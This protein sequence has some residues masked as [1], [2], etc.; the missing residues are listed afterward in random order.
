MGRVF[1]ALLAYG[2]IPAVP[3]HAGIPLGPTS[4]DAALP[5]AVDNSKLPAF[6]PMRYMGYLKSCN[7][8]A[9]TYYQLTHEVA[10]A[11]GWTAE[12]TA[13]RAFSPKWTYN[14]ANDGKDQGAPIGDIY[15][16]LLQ[17]GAPSWTAFPY[18]ET[19]TIAANYTDWTTQP[20]IWLDALNYRIEQAGA[21]EYGPASDPT[22]IKGPTSPGLL[23]L[24]RML[25]QGH[26]LLVHTPTGSITTNRV[27]MAAQESYSSHARLLVG[28]DDAKWV[29]L[30]ANGARDP[31]EFGAFK[32]L[33]N[34]PYAQDN[35]YEWLIYDA[36]N[37]V[38]SVANAQAIY[39]AP[40]PEHSGWYGMRLATLNPPDRTFGFNDRRIY[41]VS[42]RPSYTPKLLARVTV[43]TGKRN[44]GLIFGVSTLD[45]TMPQATWK[46][47]LLDADSYGLEFN[48][49]RFAT[50]LLFDLT[51]LASDSWVRDGTAKRWYVQTTTGSSLYTVY[52]FELVDPA[53]NTVLAK[54]T[55]L[56]TSP[57]KSG[58]LTMG[59][60]LSMVGIPPPNAAARACWTTGYALPKARTSGK[61]VYA[62]GQ[63]IGHSG[64]TFPY[65]SGDA[66]ITHAPGNPGWQTAGSAGSP[67]NSCMVTDGNRVFELGG[68]GTDLVQE[69]AT[70][71]SWATYV[72]LPRPRKGMGASL[73]DGRLYAFGGAVVRPN[74]EMSGRPIQDTVGS[75]EICDLADSRWLTSSATLQNAR[76]KPATAVVGGRIFAIGGQNSAD[77]ESSVPV[78]TV[79]EYDPARGTWRVVSRLPATLE[80]MGAASIAGDIY[81]LAAMTDWTIAEA[82]PVVWKY[83]PATGAWSHEATLPTPRY[84][85]GM[86]AVNRKLYFLGGTISGRP[87]DVVEVLDTDISG[88]LSP[89]GWIDTPTANKAVTGALS[90]QGWFLDPRGVAKIEVLVDDVVAG[91]ASTGLSRP[92]VDKAY[93]IYTSPNTGFAY[94]MGA[95]KLTEGAHTLKVRATAPDGSQTIVGT[96]A[97]S[98]QLQPIGVLD[99]PKPGTVDGPI[100]VSGW[101]LDPRGVARIEMLINGEVAHEAIVSNATWGLPRGDVLAVYPGY[102]DA[103]GGFRFQL[104]TKWWRDFRYTLSIRATNKDGVQTTFGQSVL[105]PLRSAR[106]FIDSP[107]CRTTLSGKVVFK[108]WVLGP[109]PTYQVYARLEN[110]QRFDNVVTSLPR[111][112]IL[113]KFPEYKNANSGFSLTLDTTQLSNGSHVIYF[114]EINSMAQQSLVSFITFDVKN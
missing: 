48:D 110:G 63:I 46:P 67:V 76:F 50:T 73:L 70:G 38:S 41:W 98:I 45:K 68:E 11:R 44:I 17:H 79:E 3:V 101:Y 61:F 23:P 8:F 71:G 83:T 74:P 31:G 20:A 49:S 103:N 29:D 78:D 80:V 64:V 109:F 91:D 104:E 105:N 62:R 65:G 90:V 93:P 32:V 4:A 9:S 107:D 85:L 108:G 72:P 95:G 24:K 87:T 19:S 16:I 99:S 47:F 5:I 94:T 10:L 14:F 81:V 53:T 102:K 33:N 30:N 66:T 82:V 26:V 58:S 56:K 54:F 100:T 15:R 75:M 114:Y 106:G 37:K 96:R 18:D 59:Q 6:P 112:E 42:A 13:A 97:V 28:Y 86:V 2:V 52:D 7:A 12:Q 27:E 43:S 34:S 36:L 57:L 22:P 39:L 113:A 35:D 21:F 89:R 1:V 111:P 92:D 25:S 84:D 69:F 77:E 51:D 60:Q 88:P 55:D 40:L